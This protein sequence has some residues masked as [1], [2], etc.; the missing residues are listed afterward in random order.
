M[1]ILGSDAPARVERQ[2][3][4]AHSSPKRYVFVTNGGGQP[5]AARAEALAARFGVDVAEWQVCQARARAAINRFAALLR[6][7][8]P[9]PRRASRRSREASQ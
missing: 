5:E 7:A 4:H 1:D 3:T 8:T 9:L 2:H 6:F